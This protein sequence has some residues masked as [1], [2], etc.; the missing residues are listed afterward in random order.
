MINAVAST[1]Y[2][3]TII[4]SISPKA[5]A[6]LDSDEF[7][8]KLPMSHTQATTTIKPLKDLV[9]P[10]IDEIYYCVR[11]G[12][13]SKKELILYKL[14]LDFNEA[15]FNEQR[16]SVS[17]ACDILVPCSIRFYKSL[18]EQEVQGLLSKMEQINQ[19]IAP[20][21]RA[22]HEYLASAS[23]DFNSDKTATTPGSFSNVF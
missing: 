12:L 13:V 20:K 6:N 14:I 11:K 19:R 16:T 7:D 4:S 10:S 2:K 22:M 5:V 23:S 3:Q 15:L 17:K 1:T 9:F 18:T 21:L 8:I